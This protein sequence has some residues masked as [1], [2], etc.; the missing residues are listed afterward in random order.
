MKDK[1][2]LTVVYRYK[3]TGEVPSIVLTG[4]WLS[5]LG[6]NIGDK[7][8]VECANNKITIEPKFE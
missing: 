7:I 3:P 5:E 8:Q 6:F 1:R 2:E 4:K